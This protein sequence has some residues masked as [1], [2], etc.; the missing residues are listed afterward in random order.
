LADK[1]PCE[2]R[3]AVE[4]LEEVESWLRARA[5][6]HL[7]L[8]A[9]M[10]AA[11]VAAGAAIGGVY[12]ALGL[13]VGA[14]L[15]AVG[16]WGYAGSVKLARNARL[17]RGLVES[18]LVDPGEYCGSSLLAFIVALEAQGALARAQR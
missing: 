14:V 10:A 2:R 15:A 3:G 7:V 11:S 13:A 16:A 18:G 5:R 4:A 8:A 6:V 9:L 17:A 1:L 12:L